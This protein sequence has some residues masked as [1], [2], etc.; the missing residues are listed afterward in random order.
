MRFARL[1]GLAGIGFVLVLVLAN[2]VLTYAGFP[3]PSEAVDH[4]EI[5]AVFAS[6]ADTLRLASTLLPAAWLLATI[7]AA[8]VFAALW[9]GDRART[10]A[11]SL[12]G[13]AGVLTQS[14]VFAGVEATRLALA[15]AAIHAPG[16]VPGLWGLYNGLFGF[17]Q[18]FLSTALVGLSISG[19][20]SRIISRWHAVV[21]VISAAML[22]LSATTSPYGNDGVNPLALLGLIGWLLWLV[23]IVAYSITLIRGTDEP[24]PERRSR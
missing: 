3:T 7:F 6:E 2:V 14:A 5:I 10:E 13:L 11:W 4:D 22:F 15:S 1:S 23:W 20:R 19:L 21:G 8:G 16:A 17:N 12:V 24:D 18:V 9:R